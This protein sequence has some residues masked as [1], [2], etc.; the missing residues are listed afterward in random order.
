MTG[1][2]V[3]AP[4]LGIAGAVI[5]ASLGQV[6]IARTPRKRIRY[7]RFHPGEPVMI[8][9][10]EAPR[11][12]VRDW[13]GFAAADTLD[14]I[15]RRFRNLFT[16]GRG[17]TRI[18]WYEHAWANAPEV[19]SGLFLDD[20]PRNFHP[21]IR[22]EG[23]HGVTVALTHS[24]VCTV[25]TN[26]LAT[27][28]EARKAFRCKHPHGDG[29]VYTSVVIDGGAREGEHGRVDRVHITH[30]NTNGAV[31]HSIFVAQHTPR[32][33]I[34]EQEASVAEAIADRMQTENDSWGEYTDGPQYV[35]SLAVK[36]RTDRYPLTWE[37]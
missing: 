17:W 34:A 12:Q 9:V 16:H 20:D 35:R 5:A 7:A 24:R 26:G 13:S 29:Q 10:P 8:E 22:R 23:D 11:E 18:D 6:P 1:H 15:E 31:R 19:E 36:V 32:A 33:L 14:E 3:I 27:E 25:G 4:A 37:R 30:R 2:G 21:A 28:D